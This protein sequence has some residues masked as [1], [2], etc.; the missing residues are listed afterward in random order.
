MLSFSFNL[1][2]VEIAKS[3][4]QNVLFFMSTITRSSCLDEINWSFCVSKSQRSLCVYFFSRDYEFCIYCL[5][6][7]S[8]FSSL[9]NSQRITFLTCLFL[10]TFFRELNAF[11]NYVIDR[12]ILIPTKPTFILLCLVYFCFDTIS[13]YGVVMCCDQKRFIFS[14]GVSLSLAC[15]SFPVWNFSGLYYHYYFFSSLPHQH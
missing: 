6:V 12:F 14:L 15:S 10:Y 4:M 13:P 8:N 2:S 7:W 3:T 5:F 11:A 1:W 9:D